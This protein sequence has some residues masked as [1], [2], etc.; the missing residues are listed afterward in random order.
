MPRFE[1]QALSSPDWTD[2]DL[3]ESVFVDCLIEDADVAGANLSGARFKDC[4]IVRSRFARCDLREAVFEDCGFADAQSR[5][6]LIAAFSNLDA[7]C[8]QI[9]R[10]RVIE[11]VPVREVAVQLFIA[12][13]TVKSKCSR[14]LDQLDVLFQD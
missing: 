8:Q 13:G 5:T 2:A 9:L 14:C 7:D 4:R 10:L 12:E 11:G 1:G 6:G 3:S